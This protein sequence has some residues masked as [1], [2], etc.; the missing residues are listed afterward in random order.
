MKRFAFATTLALSVVL[1]LPLSA[2]EA[3]KPDGKQILKK[4][5]ATLGAAKQVSFS[6]K[7]HM[8]A[9]L[10]PGTDIAEDAAITVSLA[11]PNQVMAV[12]TNDKGVQRLIA[13]GKTLTLVDEKMNFYSSTPMRVSIDQLVRKLDDV[14]GF[15]PPVAEFVLS[16]VYELGLSPL[17]K[18]V[19]YG[20][21]ATQAGVEC[22]RILLSGK[23]ADAELLVG[24][25]DSLPYK[26]VAI[27]HRMEGQPQV[28]VE[29]ADWNLAAPVSAETFAF[30]PAAGA[31]KIPLQAVGETRASKKKTVAK[32]R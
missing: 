10:F 20:G 18:S 17:S 3:A 21:T 4:M 31:E 5:S 12:S 2:A 27:F 7:R 15:A 28:R 24:V 25:S 29:F 6:A 23:F 30:T 13:D 11:R 32:S 9:A 16:N 1:G 19:K 26:L 8:D 14:Y 22:H